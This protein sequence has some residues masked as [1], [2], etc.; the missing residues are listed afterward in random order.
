M[1][2]HS[3]DWQEEQDA[4]DLWRRFQ[5]EAPA[6]EGDEDPDANDLAAYLDGT[7][8]SGA[9]EAVERAL[10]ADPERIDAVRELRDL[11]SSD[12]VAVPPALLDA[13]KRLGPAPDGM[14]RTGSSSGVLTFAAARWHWAAAAAAAVVFSLLGYDMGLSTS[15]MRTRALALTGTDFSAET[16]GNGN[17][18]Q[19]TKGSRP[20]DQRAHRRVEL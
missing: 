3:E 20:R 8:E 11:T 12:P 19:F 13:L 18:L 6:D 9:A 2:G 1:Q 15:R 17:D 10:L 4:K 5:A 16:A 7:A 14:D